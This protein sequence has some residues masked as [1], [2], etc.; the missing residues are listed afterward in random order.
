MVRPVDILAMQGDLL[1]RYG[2]PRFARGVNGYMASLIQQH[3]FL[4]G[5]SIDAD[6]VDVVPALSGHLKVADAYRIE[7]H[8]N[9]RII[10]RADELNEHTLFG[11]IER[12]SATGFVVFEEPI[13]VKEARGREEAFHVL[14]WGPSKIAVPSKTDDGW[15]YEA[16]GVLFSAWNDQRREID[17]VGRWNRTKFP[18][19]QQKLLGEVNGRWHLSHLEIAGPNWPLAPAFAQIHQGHQD[20]IRSAGDTP[21]PDGTRN[22][23]RVWFA[24]FE[25]LT[26]VLPGIERTPA[27]ITAKQ[28]RKAERMK[29]KPAVDLVTLRRIEQRPESLGT[30][31]PIGVQYHV[32]SFP[33]TYHRGTPEEFT[34]YVRPHDRGPKDAPWSMRRK[35]RNLKR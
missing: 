17:E 12:P 26:E 8:M 14:T 1:A 28:A 9:R 15:H 21:N 16:D 6:D 35:V 11:A 22:M 31:S 27:E 4:Q 29:I 3:D 13:R 25:M 23:R 32:D 34:I 24:L 2:D 20:W 10:A 7:A 5:Q 18:L 19:D 30:G 33:R